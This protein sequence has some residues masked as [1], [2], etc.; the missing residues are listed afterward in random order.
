MPNDAIDDD[1]MGFTSASA[2]AVRFAR[3]VRESKESDEWETFAGTTLAEVNCVE[4]MPLGGA[5]SG[6][7]NLPP[8]PALSPEKDGD[9]WAFDSMR[10]AMDAAGE[11][12]DVEVGDEFD[13]RTFSTTNAFDGSDE[14]DGGRDASFGNSSSDE[15]DSSFERDLAEATEAT[16]N[17]LNGLDRATA[18]TSICNKADDDEWNA[19]DATADAIGGSDF[20]NFGDIGSN[21]SVSTAAESGASAG[22]DP[23]DRCNEV[24]TDSFAAFGDEPFPADFDS[25]SANGGSNNISGADAAPFDPFANFGSGPSTSSAD[26]EGS[27]GTT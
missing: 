5:G 19:F 6:D 27:A 18:G 1:S 11:Q 15:E 25:T 8:S 17:D 4:S 21:A 12:N 7:L 3:L 13:P 22:S 9:I 26:S 10:S 23:S 20:A 24:A 14:E 2:S 16:E